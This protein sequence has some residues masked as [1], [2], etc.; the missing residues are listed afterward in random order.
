MNQ[1]DQVQWKLNFQ[2]IK[3]IGQVTGE[4]KRQVWEPTNLVRIK[5]P[6]CVNEAF[7]EKNPEVWK[8]EL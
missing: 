6:E 4:K 2:H 3:A 1:S 7:A 8:I 5:V